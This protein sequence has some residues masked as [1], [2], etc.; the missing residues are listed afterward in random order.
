ML[1][2]M[3]TI[4]VAIG[5]PFAACFQDKPA[6]EAKTPLQVQCDAMFKDIMEALA[7]VH[8]CV[9]HKAR[10]V[11]E[12]QKFTLPIPPPTRPGSWSWQKSTP[13]TPPQ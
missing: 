3:M 13:M 8:R 5:T 4:A 6:A 11:E 12:A 9:T 10:T 2:H 1:V 7:A